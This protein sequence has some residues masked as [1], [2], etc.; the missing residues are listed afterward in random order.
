VQTL[1]G[2]KTLTD[3]SERH[4]F[5]NPDGASRDVVLPTGVSAGFDFVIAETEGGGYDLNVKT[6]TSTGVVNLGYYSGGQKALVVY[7][8]TNWRS[9]TFSG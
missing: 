9:F 4:Q 3:T 7:D 8:G 6:N 1:A 5:L 2:T